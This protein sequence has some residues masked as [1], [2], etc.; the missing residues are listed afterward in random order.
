MSGWVLDSSLALAWGLPDETSRRA[1]RFLERISPQDELWVPGL[2]WYEIA[3]ALAVAQRRRRLAEAEALRLVE[4]YR[5]LPLETDFCSGPEALWRYR[6]LSLEHGLSVYDSVYLEL[7]A[8]RGLALAS[9][10]RSLVSAA[11][12]AGVRTLP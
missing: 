3:N 7:A 9:L 5:Q 8:R 4:M 2:W 11:H 1:E 6:G 10:D 12:R